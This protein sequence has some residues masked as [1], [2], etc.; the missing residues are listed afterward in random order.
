MN[1]ETQLNLFK[2]FTS[3]QEEILKS[4]AHDYANEDVLSNFKKVAHL[5]G[6]SNIDPILLAINTKI[7][8]LNNLIDSKEPKNESI[9]DTLVDLCNYTFLLYAM[10]NENS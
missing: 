10:L 3:K 6:S 1:K 2:K 4:K 5:K 7:V 8:R 9:E